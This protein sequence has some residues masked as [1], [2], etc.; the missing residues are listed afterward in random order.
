MSSVIWPAK[1]YCLSRTFSDAYS[2]SLTLIIRYLDY[3][4]GIQV[5]YVIWADPQAGK[6]RGT[7]ILEQDLRAHTA[8]KA[9][10]RFIGSDFPV[11]DKLHRLK[12]LSPFSWGKS[13]WFKS[14][15]F[16][17]HLYRFGQ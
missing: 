2:T 17:Y 1:D 14:A 9:P 6:A 15:S 7:L 10:S 11:I 5:G 13:R 3:A 16:P 12:V 4:A 8:P